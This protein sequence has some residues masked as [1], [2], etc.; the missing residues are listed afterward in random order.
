MLATRSLGGLIGLLCCA[1]L[2]AGCGGGGGGGGPTETAASLTEEGWALYE[3]GE[4]GAAV[5]K[6]FGATELDASYRDAYNGLGWTYGKMDSLEKAVTNFEICI[7]NGD[8]RP[9]PRAGKA[10]VCRDLD[11]PEY[12]EAIS[13]ADAALSLDADFV[14]EHYEDFNWRDLRIIK[15]QC[16][17]ALQEYAEAVN[18]IEALGGSVSDPTSAAEIA[19]EI[20]DLEAQYGG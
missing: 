1:G 13:A 19:E 8:T 18:E 5:V 3:D 16:Y 15:A 6:F 20:E 10:P 4:Y 2:L 12:E 14:F 9:D 17:F 7:S 11:P